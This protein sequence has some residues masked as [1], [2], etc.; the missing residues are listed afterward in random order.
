MN[1]RNSGTLNL[2]PRTYGIQ[3][4]EYKLPDDYYSCKY[5]RDLLSIY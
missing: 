2:N 1:I 5:A 3:E 4:Y